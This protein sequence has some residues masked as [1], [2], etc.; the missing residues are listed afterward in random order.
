M[1]RRSALKR[2][3]LS[4]LV[5]L[6]CLM[7]PVA[8]QAEGYPNHPVRILVPWPAGH[9]ADI[10]ARLLAPRL[11][12]A[13]GQTFYVDN[14]GGAAGVIGLTQAKNAPADGYTILLTSGGPVVLAPL[15]TKDLAYD[16]VKDFTAV[17]PIGW[18]A[19]ILVTRP[20]FPASSV[21]E[22]IAYLRANPGKVSFSST[23]VT[24]FNRLLMEMLMR[25]T[26]TKMTHVPYR[27]EADQLS[28]LMSGTVD[29]AFSGMGASTP[30][31]QGK[32]VKGLAVALPARNALV[33]ELPTFKEA[34]TPELVKF[35]DMGTLT[36]I[37]VL[38][39]ARTP[40]AVVSTL[41]REVNKILTTAEF[42]SALERQGVEPSQAYSPADF[43]K[44][45]K[46]NI[47]LWKKVIDDAKITAE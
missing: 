31:V 10:V 45:I 13:L 20:N 39:P 27:G 22:L 46:E 23:G 9:T 36:W 24:S 37:G 34:G 5:A 40:E 16:P 12:A 41:N 29:I 2:L 1:Q 38:A 42:R 47:A 8:G 44:T 21:P 18:F 25:L 11:Q 17:A 35:V 19:S 7:W 14:V 6:Q 3:A 28:A 4:L 26:D 33:P 30:L 43:G 32:K 15:F